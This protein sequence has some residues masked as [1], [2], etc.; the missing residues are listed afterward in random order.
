[1]YKGHEIDV[2]TAPLSAFL[3]AGEPVALLKVDVVGVEL[4]L[5]HGIADAQW[6]LIERVVVDAQRVGGRLEAVC[7][8]LTERGLRVGVRE[9]PAASGDGLNFMV[10]AARLAPASLEQWS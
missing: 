7:A 8:Y 3:P 5:F 6:A 1:M 9:N 10:H 2:S 4:D